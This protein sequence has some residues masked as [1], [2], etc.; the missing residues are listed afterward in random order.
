MNMERGLD[1]LR[2]EWLKAVADESEGLE[3]GPVFDRLERKYQ[4]GARDADAG[5][6]ENEMRGPAKAEQ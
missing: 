6:S 3:P 2:R 1:G 5:S 4:G